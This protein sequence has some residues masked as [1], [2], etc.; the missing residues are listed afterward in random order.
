MGKNAL[1]YNNLV[2]CNSAFLNINDS[3]PVCSFNIKTE[4]MN[5]IL[6]FR[7]VVHRNCGNMIWG[8]LC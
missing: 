7:V 6:P 1:E 5:V 8:T 4:K 3:G 2:K